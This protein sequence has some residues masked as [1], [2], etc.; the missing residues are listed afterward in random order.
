MA[1]KKNKNNTQPDKAASDE[2][3]EAPDSVEVA[4]AEIAEVEETAEAADQHPPII[5][6]E[7]PRFPIA[8]LCASAG[9]LE[10][11]K[12]FLHHMPANLQDAEDLL[13]ELRIHQIELEIQN[14]ELRRAE[15]ALETS[16]QN[17]YLLYDQAP[18][19][20]FVL[21]VN[22]VVLSANRAGAELLG[23]APAQVL[24]TRFERFVAHHE[25]DIFYLHRQ[26]V[27]DT[28]ER[29]QVELSL[30]A[31]DRS[32]RQA[33]LE[34]SLRPPQDD[35]EQPRLLVAAIDRTEERRLEEAYRRLVEQSLQGLAIF[36]DERLVFTNPALARMTGYSAAE[37][38]AMDRAALSEMIHPEDREAVWT[39][40]RARL[41]G[42]APASGY[43]LRFVHRSG[44]V[45]WAETHAALIDYQGRPAVHA[46]LLDI[47]ARKTAEL[48]LEQSQRF[49]ER[50]NNVAPVVI[51]IY[52]VVT[53][54]NV[55]VNEQVEPI[56]G[57]TVEAFAAFQDDVV[58]SLIHPDD[59]AQT[60]AHLQRVISAEETGDRRVFENMYRIRHANGTW[61]W[62]LSRDVV[63]SRTDEGRPHY[64]LGTIQDITRR[65]ETEA[66]QARLVKEISSQ[67]DEL[68]ALSSR[69]AELQET[70]R[71]SL[72]RE[73]HD[74]LGQNL[75]ALGFNLKF[76]R[77]QLS[78]A[79]AEAVDERLADSLHLLEETTDRIRDVMA[80]LRPPMMEEDGL[81]D[82]LEWYARQFATRTGLDIRVE[83]KTERHRLTA[84]AEIAMFRIVQEA[85]TNAAKHA[86]AA[87]ARIT[88]ERAADH[89]RLVIADDGVGFEVMPPGGVPPPGGMRLGLL[90]MQER[91]EA[92][93]GR[94]R[95]ES[96]P[97]QGTS[98]IVEV[99]SL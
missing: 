74:R 62:V 87:T 54:R 15:Q 64:V 59:R 40:S 98:I 19:G 91:A 25:R 60:E 67:R 36:Q 6:K 68:R 63:F 38:L 85:L 48:A 2:Q 70:E 55:Y 49:I 29:Q 30:L 89:Y 76:V 57:Y 39:R 95:I 16:H 84:A 28:A 52:D 12:E 33:V 47:T 41:A 80:D 32:A 8:A 27:I 11:L 4:G 86:Q 44:L 53:G 18:I 61:R 50:V 7:Q 78:A 13:E 69:L 73:L 35:E 9:G 81:A 21:D 72:A 26:Q 20:Y 75:T 42:E 71:E 51:Y 34:S 17:Y 31:S 82:S 58:G 99:P 90:T 97:G 88:L 3:A 96:E 94:F 65:K 93:G 66:E 45:R 56:L 77:G 83:D 10:V 23:Y 46:T 37:L 14:E 24:D 22:G 92:V 5:E 79:S 1:D 43:Q